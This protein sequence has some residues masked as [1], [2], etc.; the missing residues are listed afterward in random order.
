MLGTE[1][2]AGRRSPRCWFPECSLTGQG[3]KNL[4]LSPKFSI[5]CGVQRQQQPQPSAGRNPPRVSAS[6]SFLS[7]S[8]FGKACV[9]SATLN[10]LVNDAISGT[11]SVPGKTVSFGKFP[12]KCKHQAYLLPLVAVWMRVSSRGSGTGTCGPQLVAPLG[13]F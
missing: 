9:L 2:R 13:K 4:T 1:D 10:L 11:L 8:F 3:L 5:L 7:F 12:I 6:L